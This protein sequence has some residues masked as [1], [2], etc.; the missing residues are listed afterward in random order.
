MKLSEDKL[1]YLIQHYDMLVPSD[2]KLAP[3][4]KELLGAGLMEIITQRVVS[5]NADGSADIGP[6]R[7]LVLSREAREL[8]RRHAGLRLINELLT[9]VSMTISISDLEEIV[10]RVPFSALP[11][12]LACGDNLVQRLAARRIRK[13]EFLRR[14]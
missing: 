9:R 5:R 1:V 13:R 3:M 7:V 2:S 14:I 11:V 12:L 4:E 10:H 8:V 6:S